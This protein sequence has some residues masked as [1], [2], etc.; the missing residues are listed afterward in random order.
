MACK[1]I[2]QACSNMHYIKQNFVEELQTID[3]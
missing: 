2:T 1:H 3:Y